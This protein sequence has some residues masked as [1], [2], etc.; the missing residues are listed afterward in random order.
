M[1]AYQEE[2]ED[3]WKAKKCLPKKALFL[4]LFFKIRF[5]PEIAECISGIDT[6]VKYLAKCG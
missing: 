2:A 1:D 6:K 4:K 3:I 5:F